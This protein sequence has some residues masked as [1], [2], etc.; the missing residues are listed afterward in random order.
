MNASEKYET[1]L[2]YQHTHN[3]STRRRGERKEKKKYLTK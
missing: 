3:W 2:I 1:T